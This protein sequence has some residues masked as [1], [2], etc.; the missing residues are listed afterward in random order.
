MI[1]CSWT[2]CFSL[3]V[4]LLFPET[5]NWNRVFGKLGQFQIMTKLGFCKCCQFWTVHLS[6]FPPV[7]Q[8]FIFDHYPP[9][10][11][12]PKISFL[13]LPETQDVWNIKLWKVLHPHLFPRWF[14]VLLRSKF[15]TLLSVWRTSKGLDQATCKYPWE[16]FQ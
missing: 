10:K 3:C 4:H 16:I 2:S 11:F 13:T 7:L 9:N 5:R 14:L 12:F 8:L 1:K 6:S 15:L